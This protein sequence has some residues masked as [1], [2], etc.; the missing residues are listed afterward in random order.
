[1]TDRKLIQDAYIRVCQDSN[2]KLDWVRAA[3]ISAGALNI[4]PIT[5][6]AQFASMETMRQIAEGTHPS[7]K[8]ESSD[9]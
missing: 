1:M 2:F 6:W 4:H 7:V 5:I 9:A 3:Q 8:E